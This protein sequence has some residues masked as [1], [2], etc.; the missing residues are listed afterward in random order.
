MKSYQKLFSG[1]FLLFS[2][3]ILQFLLPVSV[4][5]EIKLKTPSWEKVTL[6]HKNN[7]YVFLLIDNGK[8][9]ECLR[10]H[11]RTIR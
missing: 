6:S 11:A 9:K 2:L 5:A 8:S 7:E 4:Y 3:A 10:G 1:V